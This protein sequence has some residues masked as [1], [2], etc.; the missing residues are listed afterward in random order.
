[1]A[2]KYPVFPIESD[3]R[4]VHHHGRAVHETWIQDACYLREYKGGEAKPLVDLLL[5]HEWFHP[6]LFYRGV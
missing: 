6:F 3:T 1:M 4:V 2:L 5:G